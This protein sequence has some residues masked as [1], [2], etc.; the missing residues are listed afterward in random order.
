MK[1]ILLA[2][3]LAL[4]GCPSV[5]V[6]P[7]PG[8]SIQTL[9]AGTMTVAPA[10][11]AAQAQRIITAAVGVTRDPYGYLSTGGFVILVTGDYAL[12]GGCAVPTGM[13]VSGCNMGDQLYILVMPSVGLGP[14]LVTT[15]LPHELC[16][17]AL[18]LGSTQEATVDVCAAAVIQAVR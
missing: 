7:S 4:T 16:H 13:H 2:V 12:D 9:T 6:R 5:P 17:G 3:C 14:A 11:Q 10:D 15:A 1:A 8:W 18:R